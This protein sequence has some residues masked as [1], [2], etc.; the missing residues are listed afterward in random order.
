[1]ASINQLL[2]P[3]IFKADPSK[4]SSAKIYKHWIRP[5]ESFVLAA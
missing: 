1:M 3:A 5:F 4:E 2:Q